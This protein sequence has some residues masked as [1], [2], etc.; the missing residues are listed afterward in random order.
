[1]IWAATE[2]W[3]I[4]EGYPAKAIRDLEDILKTERI[5]SGPTQRD[6]IALAK[7]LRQVRK[8]TDH[9]PAQNLLSGV[10]K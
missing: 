6:R 10:G 1:M 2:E 7:E 5:L 8:T 9:L 4:T 3:L